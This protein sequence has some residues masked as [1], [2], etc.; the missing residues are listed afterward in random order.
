M[1]RALERV[2]VERLP[3]LPDLDATGVAIAA[4]VTLAVRFGCHARLL[5]SHGP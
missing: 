2:E 5:A 1:D 4:R 3:V